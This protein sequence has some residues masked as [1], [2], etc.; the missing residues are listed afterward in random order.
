MLHSRVFVEMNI[1]HALT[2]TFREN[3]AM[4]RGLNVNTITRPVNQNYEVCCTGDQAVNSNFFGNTL[5]DTNS[6]CLNENITS[7]IYSK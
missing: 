3:F 5:S 1:R 2:E 7:Q 4:K 6:L